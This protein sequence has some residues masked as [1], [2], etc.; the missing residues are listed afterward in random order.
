MSTIYLV[1]CAAGTHSVT[2]ELVDSVNPLPGSDKW[3]TKDTDVWGIDGGLMAN[4]GM[5]DLSLHGAGATPI[6]VL[7]NFNRSTQAGNQG[8]GEYIYPDGVFPN[9]EFIW[10]CTTKN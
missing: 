10:K 8:K 2:L 5:P 7:F 1:E 9:G 4:W 3:S 6:A